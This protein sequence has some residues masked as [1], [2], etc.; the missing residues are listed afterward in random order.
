MLLRSLSEGAL[1]PPDISIPP[2][3]HL[4]LFDLE[5]GDCL[6][7]FKTKHFHLSLSGST[8]GFSIFGR[9]G[10]KHFRPPLSGSIC[11]FHVLLFQQFSPTSFQQCIG[12]AYTKFLYGS[13]AI[14]VSSS[15]C[16][17]RA[18]TKFF[19]NKTSFS[20]CNGF[21]FCPPYTKPFC[22]CTS[23]L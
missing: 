17:G 11:S 3:P 20:C 10:T 8:C 18:Y 19:C 2:Y 14:P 15:S 1:P 9:F 4:R 7:A 12:R 13:S 6:Y 16:I 23:F 22:G 5:A 21:D